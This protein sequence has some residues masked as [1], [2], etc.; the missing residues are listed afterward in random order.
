MVSDK[1]FVGR[2]A[3]LRLLRDALAGGPD[4]PSVLWVHG[5]GGI[6]TSSGRRSRSE[7]GV[8]EVHACRCHGETDLAGSGRG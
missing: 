7:H 2:E 5:P 4:A 3:E 8:H 6:D 1:V